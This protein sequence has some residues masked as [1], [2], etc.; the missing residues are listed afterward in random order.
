ML[1]FTYTACQDNRTGT[2]HLFI[3]SLPAT[4]VPPAMVLLQFV[5]SG[6]DAAMVSATG[7]VAA[8]LHDFL[9]KIYPEFAGGRN[10]LETPAFI[11]RAFAR[12]VPEIIS[13]GYG[14]SFNPSE[15]VQGSSSGAST[16]GVLPEAW[17]SRGSGHRLG[18]D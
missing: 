3:V 9:T 13:R 6:P 5:L 2:Q 4:W 1:A 10:L 14:T 8:H 17:R 7:L 18:G 15:K 16:G 11:Q 12:G